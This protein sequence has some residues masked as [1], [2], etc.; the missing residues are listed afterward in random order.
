MGDRLEKKKHG[1][2][3]D[4]LSCIQVKLANIINKEIIGDQGV[5]HGGVDNS[6]DVIGRLEQQGGDT[7]FN[8]YHGVLPFMKK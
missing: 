7:S 2:H 1:D 6:E 4:E 3:K 5:F 8:T